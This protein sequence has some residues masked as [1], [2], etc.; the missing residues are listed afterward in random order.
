[1]QVKIYNKTK[2]V[3]VRLIESAIRVKLLKIASVKEDITMK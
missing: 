1:M 3:F 2:K